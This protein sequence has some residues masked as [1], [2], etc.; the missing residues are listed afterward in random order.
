MDSG[1]RQEEAGEM[2]GKI[3]Q[4]GDRSAGFSGVVVLVPLLA[5]EVTGDLD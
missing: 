1:I 3:F 4:R 5:L 2:T